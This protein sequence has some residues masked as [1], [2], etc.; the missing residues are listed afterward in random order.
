L[1]RLNRRCHSERSEESLIVSSAVPENDESEMFRFAQHD[2]HVVVTFQPSLKRF[3]F[4]NLSVPCNFLQD[5][6]HKD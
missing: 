6:L 5:V 3:N 4:C 2:S 1:K